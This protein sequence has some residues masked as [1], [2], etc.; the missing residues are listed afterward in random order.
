MAA[1]TLA[2]PAITAS[3]STSPTNSTTE[4]LAFSTSGAA[5]Y[6]CSLNG[7]AFAACTSPKIYGSAGSPI[8]PGSY[9][10]QVRAFDSK[11]NVSPVSTFAW[12]VD[13]TPPPTPSMTT[14]PPSV[15]TSSSAPFG[16]SD[17]EAGVSYLCKLD[18]GS[19]AACGN[20]AT[21]VVADGSHT[22]S[23]E[24]RDSAGNVS[25]GAA[26][27][28]WAVDATPP[29]RP[30][31][32]NGPNN[33]WDSSTVMFT[34]TDPEANVNFQCSVDGGA[35]SPCTSPQTYYAMSAGTHEF[36]VRAKDQAGNIGDFNGWK[37]QE[38]G[39]TGTGQ[40]FV[41]SG[42][43][44]GTLYPGGA[45]APINL[46]LKNP[47]SV[48]IYVSSV[49]VA[50]AAS[51]AVTGPNITPTRPCTTS[52]FVVTQFSGPVSAANPIV[53]PAGQTVTLQGLGFVPSA[54]P[55]VRMK[56]TGVLQDGCKGATLKCHDSAPV[57]RPSGVFE[58]ESPHARSHW[59]RDRPRSCPCCLGVLD[60]RGDGQWL[61]DCRRPESTHECNRD[62]NAWEQFGVDRVDCTE[63]AAG[64]AG[65]LRY[66]KQRHDVGNVCVEPVDVDRR[67]LLQ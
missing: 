19:Y 57:V 45:P 25:T 56:E 60:E 28:G 43:A 4:T 2:A 8:A 5:R 21:F 11:N 44:N 58:S 36:D 62:V 63:R 24:A 10:F 41:I 3:P 59:L 1:N 20:P 34:F 54:L 31:V 33:K 16:F 51:S 66:A 47:N 46:S 52:D 6:E 48:T 61:G 49:T 32:T 53:I 13:R 7:A 67:Y 29:P 26:F 40:P 15:S 30:M 12:V 23:V 39:A 55:N 14:K 64:P 50:W 17:S 22:L 18:A 65:V 9:T 27:Y 38:N 42:S 37:W 35:W